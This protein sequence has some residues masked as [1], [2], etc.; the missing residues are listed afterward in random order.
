M[1]RLLRYILLVCLL[2]DIGMV[3]AAPSDSR[4]F[5]TYCGDA[6][7]RHCVRYRWWLF[8]WHYGTKC[9]NIQFRNIRA[10]LKHFQTPQGGA[11][12]R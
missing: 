9:K 1:K 3:A 12:Q 11:G 8:G 10:K 6:R 5:G 4:F 7:V 2:P